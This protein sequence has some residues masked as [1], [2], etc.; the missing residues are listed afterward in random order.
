MSS[1]RLALKQSLEAAGKAPKRKTIV[2]EYEA[3]FLS[4]RQK[5]KRQKLKLENGSGDE[6][7]PSVSTAPVAVVAAAAAGPAG[8]LRKK[9]KRRSKQMLAAASPDEVQLPRK[10]GRP[11]K[12]FPAP[13]GGEQQPVIKRKPGRPR[14]IRPVIDNDVNQS[15]QQPIKVLSHD[16]GDDVSITEQDHI[17]SDEDDGASRSSRSSEHEMSDL[18]DE[19]EES[20]ISIENKEAN[21]HDLA[22]RFLQAKWKEKRRLQEAKVA[23]IRRQLSITS[24]I[25]D[26]KDAAPS[27]KLPAITSSSLPVHTSESDPLA[28]KKEKRRLKKMKL[29]AKQKLLKKMH[30]LSSSSKDTIDESSPLATED[31]KQHLSSNSDRIAGSLVKKKRNKRRPRTVPPPTDDVLMRYRRMSIEQKRDYISVG[32]RVKVS[33]LTCE[34]QFLFNTQ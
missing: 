31:E 5:L 10:P 14:K 19:N 32:H 8:V 22:A 9:K 28:L 4:D 12:H 1:L 15:M 7:S 16:R 27:E 25:D 20:D 23:A 21:S 24:K 3:D 26:P 34:N 29:A 11:R 18:D 13:M 30:Q 33:S 17:S 6:V 2:S